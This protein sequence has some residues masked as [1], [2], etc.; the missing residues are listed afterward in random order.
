MGADPFTLDHKFKGKPVSSKNDGLPDFSVQGGWAPDGS[1]K[2]TGI[3]FNRLDQ[4]QP[5][6][7]WVESSL[8]GVKITGSSSKKPKG[9][10]LSVDGVQRWMNQDTL[11]KGTNTLVGM[12]EQYDSKGNLVQG[13]NYANPEY[14]RALA[15]QAADKKQ[16]ESQQKLY[17]LTGGLLGKAKPPPK[18]VTGNKGSTGGSEGTG[19]Y[20]TGRPDGLS[21]A[22]K[23][24]SGS[25]ASRRGQRY[26][27]QAQAFKRDPLVHTANSI[28]SRLGRSP[29]VDTW[30]RV[31][32]GNRQEQVNYTTPAKN[33]ITDYNTKTGLISWA[34]DLDPEHASV[35]NYENEGV[36]MDL[37]YDKIMKKSL[38]KKKKYKTYY[39]ADSEVKDYQYYSIP[40][41]DFTSY[42]SHKQ[43]LISSIDARRSNQ[44]YIID[45]I[46]SDTK[47]LEK[48]DRNTSLIPTLESEYEILDTKATVLKEQVGDYDWQKKISQD[49]FGTDIIQGDS[50]VGAVLDSYGGKI[51][52]GNYYSQDIGKLVRKTKVYETELESQITQK[53]KDIASI[54]VDETEGLTDYYTDKTDKE[55]GIANKDYLIKSLKLTQE[56]REELERA[57]RAQ[58]FGSNQPA[59]QYKT[60]QAS[61]RPSL[62]Q[63]SKSSR[64]YQNK[65]TRGGKNNLGGLV[66]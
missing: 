65:R 50:H 22:V 25:K 48:K 46:K 52:G 62:K 29:I 60:Q 56:E 1:W 55:Y 26:W 34:K 57:R 47:T 15:Q 58:A 38:D 59:R 43:N 20:S 24:Y 64:Q 19:S 13:K 40:D 14:G 30:R 54:D 41:E 28:Q 11:V 32:Y 27:N 42:E 16:Q 9:I 33:I 35:S 39:E 51:R 63:K 8:K 5:K 4:K 21:Y 49:S 37:T 53:K 36:K 6:E 31:G 10:M 7:K 45:T 23:S 2:N 61:G 12:A 17:E 18:S 44:K 3:S 66:I